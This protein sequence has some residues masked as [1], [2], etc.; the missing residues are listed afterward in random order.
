MLDP[1]RILIVE[2]DA[3]IASFVVKG[4]KQEGYAVD[5]AADGDTGLSLVNTTSYDVAVVDVMLP[6]LD[7]LSLV[8]RLRLSQTELPVLFLSA[9]ST[10]ED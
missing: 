9:R 3:K 7:G 10:V 1:V 2:D 8:K 4:L 6:G 5:H